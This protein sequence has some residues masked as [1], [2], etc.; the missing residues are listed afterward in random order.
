MS[1]PSECPEALSAFL[2]LHRILH[3]DKYFTYL[4]IL[5]TVQ[6]RFI[7]TLYISSKHYITEQ[8]YKSVIFITTVWGT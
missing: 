6:P 7:E 5:V 3:A 2:V 8:K 4:L 1:E